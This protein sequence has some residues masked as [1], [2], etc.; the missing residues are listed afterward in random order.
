MNV[1]TSSG[2]RRRCAATDGSMPTFTPIVG[3][4][5]LRRCVDERCEDELV[6]VVVADEHHRSRRRAASGARRAHRPSSSRGPPPRTRCGPAARAHRRCR[7]SPHARRGAHRRR[8]T[9]CTD[10]RATPN[11]TVCAPTTSPD[12]ERRCRPG[13]R[14]R[15]RAARLR[16]RCAACSARARHRANPP[17]A[18]CAAARTDAP[19][20]PSIDPTPRRRR[21]RP[22]TARGARRRRPPA[23]A[24][25]PD[26][27]RWPT[28]FRRCRCT[29]AAGRAAQRRPRQVPCGSS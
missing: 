24:P 21:A 3:D 29:T 27:R 2:E 26:W 7:R 22:A 19:A 25:L 8:R 10:V 15:D 6:A 16:A 5:D 13:W 17:G 18:R 14:R 4:L 1:S 11:R 23:I 20:R 28:A 9:R 12:D